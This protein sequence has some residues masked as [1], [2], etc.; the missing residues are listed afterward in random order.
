MVFDAYEPSAAEAQWTE[1]VRRE[2]PLICGPWRAHNP[3]GKLLATSA[4]GVLAAPPS[5]HL[6][7]TDEAGERR[8]SPIEPLVASLRHPLLCTPGNAT[9]KRLMDKGFIKLPSAQGL[10]R[11]GVL[12]KRA[13]LIDLGA[14]L[15]SLGGSAGEPGSIGGGGLYW[16]INSFRER[17]VEFDR[18]F[19]W[20]ARRL[21]PATLWGSIPAELVGK[22]SY[23]NT[24]ATSAPGGA[25]NPWR[26]LAS[27][28]SPDDYVVVKIDIDHSPTELALVEQARAFIFNHSRLLLGW[29]RARC[30]R[31]AARPAHRCPAA[32]L[33]RCHP[34]A[35]RADP[36][37]RIARSRPHRRALLGAPRH[38]L[39]RRVPADVGVRARDGLV[40]DALQRVAARANARGVVRALQ[41]DARARDPR[42][43]LGVTPRSGGTM[44]VCDSST[45]PGYC[46]TSTRGRA[47]TARPA[48]VLT[49]QSP[50]GALTVICIDLDSDRGTAAPQHRHR[51]GAGGGAVPVTSTMLYAHL[52]HGHPSSAGQSAG[53]APLGTAA[54][55]RRAA[56]HIPP[57]ARAARRRHLTSN[58][59]LISR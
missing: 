35:W 43:Q 1:L 23:F 9:L 58:F 2:N 33:L 7:F 4:D 12:K 53:G 40:Q 20:E 13:I 29:R 50:V 37:R 16:L 3:L 32:R 42:A 44:T 39:A 38:R 30:C 49:C 57:P 56:A 55:R 11:V 31:G 54:H 10:R 19:A 24:P 45:R 15:Y 48:P 17:G 22:F 46:S 41:A 26:V 25:H 52:R 8:R 21:N 28:A 36:R 27:V 14:G 6:L 51:G 18:I 47:A 59:Y 5:S 34:R